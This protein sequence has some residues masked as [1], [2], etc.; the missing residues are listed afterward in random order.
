[1]KKRNIVT[2]IIVLAVI[3]LAIIVLTRSHPD[4]SEEI[5]KCIGENSVL[6][7]QKGCHAC[8]YQESLFGE[9]SKY[10]EIIDC[11]EEQEK[12]LGIITATP[13]WIING[14]KYIGSRKIEE[15]KELTGC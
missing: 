5:V 2:L 12:C 3:L 4:T 13:T 1:M 15:L 10:L 11:W 8:E 14:E 9:N 6:Y 7:T